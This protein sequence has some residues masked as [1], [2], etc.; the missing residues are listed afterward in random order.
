VPRVKAVLRH[1]PLMV[2]VNPLHD[3]TAAEVNAVLA[4]GADL[5]MLPMF[6]HSG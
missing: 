3:G 4:A 5:L 6:H 1:A 2:R